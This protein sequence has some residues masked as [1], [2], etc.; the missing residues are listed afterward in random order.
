MSR[1]ELRIA[2]A[3][4]PAATVGRFPGDGTD[5]PARR[6]GCHAAHLPATP[7]RFSGMGGRGYQLLRAEWS[8]V[9]GGVL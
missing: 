4:V 8:V 2:L 3:A 9:V 5:P 7:K 1:V 6:G